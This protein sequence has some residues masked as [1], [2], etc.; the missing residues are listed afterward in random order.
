MGV[1][2]SVGETGCVS[3]YFCCCVF[4]TKFLVEKRR[5]KRRK[6]LAKKWNYFFNF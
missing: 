2:M 4:G 6:I 5:A 3:V 1:F